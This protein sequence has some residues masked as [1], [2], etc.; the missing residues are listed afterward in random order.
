MLYSEII[1][2]RSQI[3]TKHI[4]TLCGQNIKLWNVKPC[5]MYIYRWDFGR[6]LRGKGHRMHITLYLFCCYVFI[7]RP[8]SRHSTHPRSYQRNMYK[9]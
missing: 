3:H 2:V 1:G 4:Y 6:L 9:D 8:G 7:S 5:G